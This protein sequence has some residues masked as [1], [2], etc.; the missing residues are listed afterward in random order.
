MGPHGDDVHA[1]VLKSWSVEGPTKWSVER[2]VFDRGRLQAS[3]GMASVDAAMAAL[4]DSLKKSSAIPSLAKRT[5][6]EGLGF[7]DQKLELEEEMAAETLRIVQLADG[8][9]GDKP[10]YV[11]AVGQQERRW[12]LFL[13]VHGYGVDVEPTTEMVREYTGFMYTTRQR[14]SRTGRPGL[15]DSLAEMAQYILAQVRAR[16]A[17]QRTRAV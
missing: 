11:A 2:P 16:G 3:P 10:K 5:V 8:K 7:D 9:A 6:L 14:A 4:G 12:R 13:A 15:G 1:N 17:T